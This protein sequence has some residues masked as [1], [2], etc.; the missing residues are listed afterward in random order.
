MAIYDVSTALWPDTIAAI[1]TAAGEGA[2]ALVRISGR[3]AIEVAE[4]IFRG[5]ERV[6]EFKSHQQH[7]GRIVVDG[8]AI[9]QVLL[10]VH[11]APHSFTG[12][13][14]IEISCH[15]GLFVTAK[16][17]EACLAAGARGARPGEFSERAFHN[18][19]LDL[20]QAEA[21]INLIRADSDLALRSANEQLAGRLGQEFRALRQELI[22]VLAHVE[23]TLD[24][25]E[26]DIAPESSAAL[27]PK[28]VSLQ[29]RLEQL[30]AGARTGRILREGLRVVI[31]GA[32]NAGKS[33]LLNRLLGSERAI[34]SEVPGTTRDIIE[35]RFAV[36]GIALRL[37]DTAGI[38]EAENCVERE[39]IARTHRSLETADLRLHMVDGSVAPSAAAVVNEDE[40]L[41]I[42]K[43]DLPLHDH[44]AQG[45]SAA[46]DAVRISCKTGAG[47][48]DLQ[49][50]IWRRIGG[51]RLAAESALAI[52]ARHHEH[53]RRAAIA[54]GAAASAIEQGAP[55]EMFGLDLRE[56]LA[57]LDELL[58]SE[59]EEAV[60]D[61]VFR[62]FCI[63]K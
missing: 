45:N 55:A 4:V 53:L 62:Q 23:A 54:L 25:P 20:T 2:I 52:N 5:Q 61:A 34:V 30:L 33:S 17:F 43:T 60:R 10:S 42:N 6:S 44:W 41:V 35:E 57:A 1:S 58:G 29:Q 37:L 32:T 18:G 12:E 56:A 59:N 13:D 14:L 28:I 8:S 63:G 40:L 3:G 48:D 22:N 39:G 51:A 7:F 47:L 24:F 16:V 36:R 49:E 38:R 11:R 19:K 31:Y 15:G 9:D 50:A 21:V 46:R 27:C 26:E